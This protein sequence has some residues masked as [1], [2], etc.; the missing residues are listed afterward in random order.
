MPEAVNP[1]ERHRHTSAHHMFHCHGPG[2]GRAFR[3]EP[4]VGLFCSMK[5]EK[6]HEKEREKIAAQLAKRG[7]S[8]NKKAP[9]VFTK[10]GVSITLE[11]VLFHGFKETIVKH[12]TA[13]R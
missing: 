4:G 1:T 7:F 13:L 2:C 9:N 8:R 11:Q 12:A 3:H 10:D 5:C 6:R